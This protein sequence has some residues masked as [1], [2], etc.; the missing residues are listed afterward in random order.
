MKKPNKL[1]SVISEEKS[2]EYF[3]RKYLKKIDKDIMQ[4][5][6]LTGSNR[7]KLHGLIKVHKITNSRTA[8]NKHDR[9]T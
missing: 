1:H 4:S 9:N 2:I 6:I 5:L 8:R 7:G 3:I